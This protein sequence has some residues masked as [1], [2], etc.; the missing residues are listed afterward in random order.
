MTPN[1]S[2][3]LS[4]RLQDLMSRD[5]LQFIEP[6]FPREA[7]VDYETVGKVKRRDR[8]FNS[9][10]TLLTMIITALQEDKSQTASVHLFQNIFEQNR[11]KLL[12]VLTAPGKKY[13]EKPRIQKSKTKEISL[14]TAAY[15]KARDR[16]EQGLIDK[17]FDVTRKG[18][19]SSESNKW[20]CRNVF[21]T[22][23][24]YLQLQDTP[25]VPGKYRVHL[26]GTKNE[27][28]YPQAL[29]QI[30]TQYGS[31]LVHAYRLGS[32]SD[33]ELQLIGP[34]LKT[35]PSDSLLL[36]DALYNCYWL[37]AELI[38]SSIDFVVP[39]KKG[40]PFKVIKKHTDGDAI[41]EV[42]KPQS[43]SM[44]NKNAPEKIVLRRIE[45]LSTEDPKIT[46]V[47][48]T[49]LLDETI[50]KE[51]IVSIYAGR[52]NIE[53]TIREVKVLMG[54]SILRGKSEDMIFKEIGVAL[55]AY[56]LV[57]RIIAES[58]VKTAFSPETDFIQ[59]FIETYKAQLVDSKGRIY[60]RWAPGRPPADYST[61][62][63]A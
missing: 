52:W 29:L 15:S 9:E 48:L 28:G 59:K 49:T 33:S 44:E 22:D 5:L 38:K 43:R 14:N 7:I 51:E 8:I 1:K 24:T 60:S 40:R 20:H 47:I 37:M 35:L 19:V 42:T 62:K 10:N 11:K 18:T 6:M 30:L 27:Q 4:V 63:V 36:A 39:D 34:I 2:L 21:I 12:H 45:Y 32:R 57:R 55:I 56:N 54:F 23:G 50:T 26:P 58:V 53:V 16:I 17:I 13:G 31:G 25:D 41:V 3:E 46:H 61:S